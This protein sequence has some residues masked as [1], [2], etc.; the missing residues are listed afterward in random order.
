M[1]KAHQERGLLILRALPIWTS[2][3]LVVAFNVY[4]TVT[5]P[6][7]KVWNLDFTS[8]DGAAMWELVLT[9]VTAASACPIVKHR[10]TLSRLITD[11]SFVKYAPVS[12]G[13]HES[14]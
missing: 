10:D 4:Y 11:W 7:S 12:I 8:M 14:V 3:M 6:A 9:T 2:F 5:D 1:S 13:T